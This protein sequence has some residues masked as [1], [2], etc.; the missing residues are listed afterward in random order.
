MN[1]RKVSG[2]W[3]VSFI[4]NV[5][6]SRMTFSLV[7]T[8][9]IFVNIFC[10]CH[11]ENQEIRIISQMFKYGNN[12]RRSPDSNW[13]FQRNRLARFLLLGL[14]QSETPIDVNWRNSCS[15][16]AQ[17]QIMR[18]R[19]GERDES[20]HRYEGNSNFLVPENL[21]SE[22]FVSAVRSRQ[23]VSVFRTEFHSGRSNTCFRT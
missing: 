18:L 23:K 9:A 6:C 4:T 14:E 10:I 15:R 3:K 11:R 19:R 5:F 20:A 17:Y 21:F 7:C 2:V 8:K 1:L 16:P 13:E 12:R 22:H